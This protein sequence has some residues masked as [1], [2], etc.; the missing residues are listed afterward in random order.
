MKLSRPRNTD[1]MVTWWGTWTTR[2]GN[3]LAV[4]VAACEP[5]IGAAFPEPSD[6]R[7]VGPKVSENKPSKVN[8]L[9]HLSTLVQIAFCYTIAN[10]AFESVS[11]R[12]EAASMLACSISRRFFF[13]FSRCKSTARSTI[14]SYLCLCGIYN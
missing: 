7:D 4:S 9:G 12:S 1:S 3:N 11:R 6:L 13:I 8:S 10:V 5:H 2:S 14:C